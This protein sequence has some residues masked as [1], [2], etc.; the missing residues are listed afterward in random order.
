M[1]ELDIEREFSA[2]HHL[3]GYDGNCSKKHGHNWTVQV[4]VRA[5]ELDGVGIAMD[6]KILKRELDAILEELDHKDLNETGLFVSKNPTSEMIA[7]FIYKRL[8]GRI[9]S[10]RLGISKVRVC[11]SRSSGAS[12]FE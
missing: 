1:F 12:Y 3:E 11:E 9:G 8:A 10:A 6:F 4:F 5:E 7:R 2:A